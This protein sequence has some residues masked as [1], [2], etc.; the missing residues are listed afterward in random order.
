MTIT[1]SNGALKMAR[2]DVVV[3]R[4]A[5]VEDLGN[6]DVLCCDKTGT[7]TEGKLKLQGYYT[8]DGYTDDALILY[9]LLCSSIKG[10]KGRKLTENPIDAAVWESKKAAELGSQLKFFTIL[11]MNEFDYER[12]RMSV[13]VRS[14]ARTLLIAKGAPESILDICETA[15]VAGT[16]TAITQ[17]LSSRIRGTVS[18]YENEGYRVIAVAEKDIETEKITKTDEN[19]LNLSGFLLFL[20]PPKKT[21]KNSLRTF[22][23]LGLTIKVISGDSPV[24]TK[25]ICHEVGLPIVEEMAITGSSLDRLTEEEFEECAQKYTVFA[26][27]APEQKYKILSVLGKTHVVGFLG[28]GVNDAPALK[29]ANVGI[30]VD[31]ASGIAKEAADIILLKKSLRVLAHGITEGRKIF[32][33]I[34]KYIMNTISANYGNMLTVAASSLFLKFIPL[35]PAQILLNNFVSD[36]PLLTIAADNVDKEFLR[37]PKRWNI[38]VISRFMI[39]FGSISVFFDLLLILPL[40]FLIKVTPE[41][42]RTAWFLESAL[43]EILVT[44]AIRTKLPFFKSRPSMLLIGTSVVTGAAAIAITYTRVGTLFFEF[45]RMPIS[46][47]TFIAGVLIAYFAAAEIVKRR[48]F[49]KVEL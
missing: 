39:Y 16:K 9:G 18:G 49:K 23:N 6:I 10:K 26:R 20:D 41:L 8:V 42:F 44:F 29:A 36:F 24:I 35:L 46:I 28:D 31:S 3:K 30:S 45:V 25:K 38:H 47:V 12:R 22:Q 40:V 7:L 32:S 37:K 5:T 1:L 43:S 15:T 21:A 34:T 33:N 11:D 13:L 48:F 19:K 2:E 4:L 17:E 14:S 27:V